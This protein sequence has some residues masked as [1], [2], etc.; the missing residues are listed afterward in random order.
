MKLNMQ[1]YGKKDNVINRLIVTGIALLTIFTAAVLL[2]KIL[3]EFVWH[4][5]K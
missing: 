1:I 5:P 3:D 2:A 4:I